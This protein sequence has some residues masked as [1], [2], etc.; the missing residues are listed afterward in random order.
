[1]GRRRIHGRRNVRRRIIRRRLLV[2]GQAAY[3]VKGVE[4]GRVARIRQEITAK[5]DA[6][7]QEITATPK[8]LESRVFKTLFAR[9]RVAPDDRGEARKRRRRRD[10]SS[11]RRLR[12]SSS[13]G[14]MMRRFILR[15]HDVSSARARVGSG[16]G[17]GI[18]KGINVV[19]LNEHELER[20]GLN[21]TFDVLE[22]FHSALRVDVRDGCI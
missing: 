4:A 2:A 20:C 10:F 18:D 15:I 7:R 16:V 8:V 3:D 9:R 6:V 1:M 21:A 14:R 13:I 19:R 11:M 12:K 22:D 5:L 17:F